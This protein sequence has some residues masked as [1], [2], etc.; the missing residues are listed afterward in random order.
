MINPWELQKIEWVKKMKK[1]DRNCGAIFGAV[2][3]DAASRPLHWN[4]DRE[5]IESLL[6]Q[7]FSQSF[8]LP[9]TRHFTY[10]Q[11][12]RTASTFTAQSWCSEPLQ[13][14]MVNLKPL[15]SRKKPNIILDC[16]LPPGIFEGALHAFLIGEFFIESIRMASVLEYVIVQELFRMGRFVALCLELK[17]FCKIWIQKT[18]ASNQLSHL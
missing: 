4:D 8:G 10:F 7:D 2:I 13:R 5:R 18:H 14:T 16:I 3:A 17:W 6:K 9:V 12:V 1:V 15:F 11:L